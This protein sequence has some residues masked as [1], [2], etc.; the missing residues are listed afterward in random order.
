VLSYIREVGGGRPASASL[1]TAN[2]FLFVVDLHL[3]SLSLFYCPLLFFTLL[4]RPI[5]RGALRRFFFR[6]IKVATKCPC[7]DPA[8][9]PVRMSPRALSRKLR[10]GVRLL[11]DSAGLQFV[12][13]SLSSLRSACLF[14]SCVL[15]DQL[16]ISFSSSSI[17]VLSGIRWYV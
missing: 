4:R 3:F 17:P 15:P 11:A 10:R 16:L 2:F 1:Q 6:S 8:V 7:Q 13:S 9:R 5:P 12:P 14:A